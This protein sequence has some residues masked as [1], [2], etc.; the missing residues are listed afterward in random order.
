AM[1]CATAASPMRSGSRSCAPG[2]AARP[3][4]ACKR[5]STRQL[6]NWKAGFASPMV[7]RPHRRETM[8]QTEDG[9]TVLNAQEERKGK[10]LGMVCY[11]LHIS[12]ALCVIAG[13]VLYAIFFHH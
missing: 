3:P 5:K 8:A 1:C 6:P 13:I 10:E 11:V 9:N 4:R 2:G 12:L 7:M